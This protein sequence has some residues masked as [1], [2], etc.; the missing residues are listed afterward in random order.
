MA[1]ETP[2]KPPTH[3]HRFILRLGPR[4]CDNVNSGMPHQTILNSVMPHLKHLNNSMSHLK[5]LN[6]SMSHLKYLNVNMP[7]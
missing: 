6:N 2:R 7:Q 3:C 5:H 1:V 4:W